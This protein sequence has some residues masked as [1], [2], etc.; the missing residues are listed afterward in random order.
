MALEK[1]RTQRIRQRDR[2]AQRAYEAGREALG[3]AA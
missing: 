1:A 3:G 2:A